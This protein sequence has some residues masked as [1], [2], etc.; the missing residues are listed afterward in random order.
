MTSPLSG[1]G[2][3]H[4]DVVA[5]A[6]GG[7]ECQSAVGLSPG[8]VTTITALGLNLHGVRASWCRAMLT[9]DQRRG[10]R[11]KR[12]VQSITDE[13]CRQPSQRGHDL[14]TIHLRRTAADNPPL[15]NPIP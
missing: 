1:L 9:T 10:R 8:H 14:R 7:E 15:G 5:D 2:F 12:G 13:W 3:R 6:V 4:L 11:V